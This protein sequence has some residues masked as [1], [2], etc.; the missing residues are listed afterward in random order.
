[1]QLDDLLSDL[2]KAKDIEAAAR[3]DVCD[4]AQDH[5]VTKHKLERAEQC[6]EAAS[7]QVERI[8]GE[9]HRLVEAQTHSQFDDELID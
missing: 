2:A 1:M 3:L 5:R 9:L 6:L 7:E 4:R 8:R